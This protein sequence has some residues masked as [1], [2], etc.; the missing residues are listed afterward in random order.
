MM[1][2]NNN[3]LQK[4]LKSES[5]RSD[6]E[7]L[8]KRAEDGNPISPSVITEESKFKTPTAVESQTEMETPSMFLNTP[9][10]VYSQTEN[11]TPSM[12]INEEGDPDMVQVPALVK[13]KKNIPIKLLSPFL[14]QY[15]HLLIGE[16]QLDQKEKD[17][18]CLLN[19]AFGEGRPT[20]VLHTDDWKIVT[21]VEF[22][23]LAPDVWVM[24][25]VIDTF[26][27]ILND[28]PDQSVKSN[29]KFY[30]STIPLNMLCQNDPYGGSQDSQATEE[31]RLENFIVRCKA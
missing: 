28:D 12:N 1:L 21:R 16:D 27:R 29:L 26:A 24:N 5:V 22:Q 23:T 19:Y 25:N 14:T 15:S 8:N 30:F 9:S 20:Q 18:R 4:K 11:V 13:R 7:D 3:H 17:M 31:K 2:T 6:M 10:A